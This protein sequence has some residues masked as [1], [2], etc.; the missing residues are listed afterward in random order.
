MFEVFSTS[1]KL[2]VRN[3]EPLVLFVDRDVSLSLRR[4]QGTQLRSMVLRADFVHLPFETIGENRQFIGDETVAT[5]AETR[6]N[7]LVVERSEETA[8]FQ[9]S[10]FQHR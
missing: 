6:R 2:F 9:R 4:S 10:I 1:I 3:F 7:V 8:D 5:A